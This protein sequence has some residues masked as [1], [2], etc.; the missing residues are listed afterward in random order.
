MINLAEQRVF[1]SAFLLASKFAT[2]QV[3]NRE[4]LVARDD[5]ERISASH[6]YDEFCTL[7]GGKSNCEDLNAEIRIYKA[8]PLLEAQRSRK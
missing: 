4:L 5:D 3:Q 6:R 8:P 1:Q 7:L 2:L